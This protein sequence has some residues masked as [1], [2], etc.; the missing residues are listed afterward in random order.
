MGAQ[1][2]AADEARIQDLVA[3][4]V[5]GARY[6]CR[7]TPGQLESMRERLILARVLNGFTIEQA[8]E[9]LGDKDTNI[10]R[11]EAGKESYPKDHRF[12]FKAAQEYAVSADFLFALTTDPERDGMN[13]TRFAFLRGFEGI[14][15]AQLEAMR[16]AFFA[17]A[18]DRG[19]VSRSEHEGVA[20]AVD[21]IRRAIEVMRQKYGFDDIRGSSAVLAAV[22][23]AERSIAP[24]RKVLASEREF[25]VLLGHLAS[26]KVGPSSFLLDEGKGVLL[27]P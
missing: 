24:A 20:A 26:G 2:L 15:R 12:V 1:A 10:A 3:A 21:G 27:E 14:V 19:R 4:K 7:S 13:S 16:Q 25:D 23:N 11:I 8:Q 5:H 6:A 17:Y 18:N 9:R 22:E